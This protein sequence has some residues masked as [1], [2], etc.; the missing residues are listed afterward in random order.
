MLGYGTTRKTDSTLVGV[1]VGGAGIFEPSSDT[2]DDTP[3]SW[4]CHT[5]L[6]IALPPPAPD[7]YLVRPK[8]VD[9]QPSRN[10]FAPPLQDIPG[11]LVQVQA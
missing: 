9:G 5:N 4:S 11:R 10:V 7:H 6:K 3:W 8:V 1:G 2:D